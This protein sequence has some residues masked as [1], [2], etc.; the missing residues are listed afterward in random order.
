VAGRLEAQQR[1]ARPGDAR[2]TD[3]ER[4]GDDAVGVADVEGLAD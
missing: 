3:L 1:F 2:L 4:K